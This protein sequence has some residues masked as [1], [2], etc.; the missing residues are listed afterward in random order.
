MLHRYI[1]LVYMYS[2]SKMILGN[3]EVALPQMVPIHTFFIRFSFRHFNWHNTLSISRAVRLK[4]DENSPTHCS[5]SA[6]LDLLFLGTG[7]SLPYLG[8]MGKRLNIWVV[9]QFRNVLRNSLS[10]YGALRNFIQ[11]GLLS[12]KKHPLVYFSSSN[13]GYNKLQVWNLLHAALCLLCEMRFIQEHVRFLDT[14]SLIVYQ[15]I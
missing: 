11:Y 6:I 2:I 9:V 13:G 8:G 1:S 10:L 3:L 7:T 12:R 15:N 14:L 5:L 4:N